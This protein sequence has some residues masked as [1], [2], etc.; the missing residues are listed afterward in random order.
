MST[1]LDLRSIMSALENAS[2]LE[3][4]R[5]RTAIAHLLESPKRILPIRQRLHTGQP[6]EYWSLRDRRTHRGRIAQFKPDQV[7]IHQDDNRLVWVEYA[8]LVIEGLQAAPEP[9]P[10]PMLTREDFGVGDSV[11]FEGRDLLQHTGTIVRLNQKTATVSCQEGE[12]RV[13][14][15]LLHRVVEI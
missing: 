6:I 15:A 10:R 1:N 3:L 14:Y 2:D 11:G 5:L 13:S 12:W 8:A 7:L 4:L 9:P